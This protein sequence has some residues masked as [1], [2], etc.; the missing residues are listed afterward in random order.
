MFT[1][2]ITL[3]TS[4]NLNYLNTLILKYSS[5]DFN[6]TLIL[7]DLKD[8]FF[9]NLVKEYYLSKLYFF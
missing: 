4:S 3:T 1:T 7:K 9:K 6:T 5:K 8:I 2:T